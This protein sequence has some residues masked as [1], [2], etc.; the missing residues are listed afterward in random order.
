[1][2]ALMTSVLDSA[3]KISGYIA[4][5]KDMGI[6]VLPPDI[7]HS[8]DQFTVDGDAIRFGLG[9]VKNVG[10]GLVRAMCAKREEGGAFKSLEDFIQRMGEEINKRA[11][12]NFIKCGA[13]DCFGHHRSELLAVYDRMMD[14]IASTRKRNLEGQIGLFSLLDDEDEA[15]SIPIPKLPEMGRGE[16]LNMEKETMGIY[17]SGHPMD[18]YRALLRNTHVVHIGDLMDE[19]KNFRDDQIVSVA[20]IVQA[21]K[22][23]TTR[24]NS[25]M[26][27]ITVEDDTASMEMLAFS[28]VLNQFGGYLKENAPVVITGRL[29]IRDEKEPQ[30]VIN[31]ARPM[32]DFA[33]HE[34][35]PEPELP[36]ENKIRQGTL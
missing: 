17:I 34:P 14:A 18:D 4:E 8:E 28:N 30:I 16:L 22:M 25:M 7:N 29:S 10:H 24:S 11:V 12:E 3:A 20:G 9:A 23:K 6:P 2:A 31:R 19:E 33:S 26:A 5:C 13:M 35:I 1:M 27:Y 36:K 32:S 21:V 15:A